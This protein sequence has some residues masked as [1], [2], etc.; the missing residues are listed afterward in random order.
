MPR[1]LYRKCMNFANCSVEGSAGE[2]AYF[3]QHARGGIV[4][5]SKKCCSRDYCTRPPHVNFE[6]KKAAFCRERVQDG[7][8]DVYHKRCS[9]DSYTKCPPFNVEGSK[10]AAFCK[11]HAE[12]GMV[13]I[14]RN[15]CSYG[16]CPRRP[17]FNVAGSKRPVPATCAGRHGQ[18]LE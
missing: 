1:C 9:H 13:H 17:T 12:N 16:S 8:V 15:L 14:W 10:T 4:C 6:G 5:I 18:R 7:M 2:P 11:Q 3:K